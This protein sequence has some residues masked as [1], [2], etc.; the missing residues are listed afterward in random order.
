M[1]SERFLD[2]LV[3]MPVTE[4]THLVVDS[5]HS[6]VLVP[7]GTYITPAVAVSNTVYLWVEDNVVRVARAGDPLEVTE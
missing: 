2:S 6:L 4:A 5:H 1:I 7:E 3:G